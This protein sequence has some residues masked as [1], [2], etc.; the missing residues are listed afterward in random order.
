M[1]EAKRKY[2]KAC[3]RRY[4]D[5]YKCDMELYEESKKINLS[6]YVKQCLKERKANNG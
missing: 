6:K 4:I 2:R 1:T 5:F 3:K